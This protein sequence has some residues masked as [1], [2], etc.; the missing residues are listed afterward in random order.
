M[1]DIILC[2]FS[3]GIETPDY[4]VVD[5]GSAKNGQIVFKA[6]FKSDMEVGTTCGTQGLINIWEVRKY[7]QIMKWI[8]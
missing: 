8:Y 5:K 6:L 4:T 3:E 1:L 7:L 2:S